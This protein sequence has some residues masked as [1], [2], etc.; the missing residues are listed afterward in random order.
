MST[1]VASPAGSFYSGPNSFLDCAHLFSILSYFL[2]V[3]DLEHLDNAHYRRLAA[4]VFP[5][6]DSVAF[7]A[8]SPTNFKEILTITELSK[9][10]KG[11]VTHTLFLETTPRAAELLRCAGGRRRLGCR[12]T[13]RQ[14]RRRCAPFVLTSPPLL[15]S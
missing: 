10:A 2:P 5:T 13:S 3:V 1:R 8:I 11:Y 6:P 4:K 7:G 14:C 15:C 12:P 9:Y